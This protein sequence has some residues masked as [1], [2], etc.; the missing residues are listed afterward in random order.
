MI[1]AVIAGLPSQET[2]LL[3][4]CGEQF[5]LV[6][7]M[8]DDILDVQGNAE[9][10]GKGTLRDRRKGRLTYPELLGETAALLLLDQEQDKLDALLDG[11][12]LREDHLAE[13]VRG[14]RHR[15]W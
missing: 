8:Q 4:A 13:Y 9:L 3:V 6:F 15:Q 2:D 5:G 10:M 11:L 7:Q 1:A 12:H 14:M